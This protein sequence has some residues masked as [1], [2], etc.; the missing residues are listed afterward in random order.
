LRNHRPVRHAAT[1]SSDGEVLF[2]G[3]GDSVVIGQ[4]GAQVLLG[5]MAPEVSDVG[6][7][8]AFGQASV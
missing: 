7:S 8:V 1:G 6:V 2:G 3:E 4:P 5:G